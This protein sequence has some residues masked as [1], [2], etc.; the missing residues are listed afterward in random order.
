MK[1]SYSPDQFVEKSMA[2]IMGKL[3]IRVI[4]LPIIVTIE[5][6][7]GGTS[8]NEDFIH[9]LYCYTSDDRKK[10]KPLPLHLPNDQDRSSTYSELIVQKLNDD[11]AFKNHKKLKATLSREYG[12]ILIHE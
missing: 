11:L 7:I 12:K 4:E 2:Y 5:D 6:T 10:V 8:S 9:Y 1:Y 3:A